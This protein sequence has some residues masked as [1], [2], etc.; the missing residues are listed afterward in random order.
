MSENIEIQK[1]LDEIQVYEVELLRYNIL[2]R[3][4]I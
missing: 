1:V 2:Q 4:M 3:V